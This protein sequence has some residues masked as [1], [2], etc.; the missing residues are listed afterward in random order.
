MLKQKLILS[1]GSK[2]GSQLLQFLGIVLIAR[3]LGPYSLGEISFAFAFVFTLSFLA[4]LGFGTAHVKLISEGENVDDCIA[5]FSMIKFILVVLFSILVLLIYN[6]IQLFNFDILSG[7]NND[8]LIYIFL[9]FAVVQQLTQVLNQT[10]LANIEQAKQDIPLL[11]QKIFLFVGRV[12]VLIYAP[13]VINLA[14]CQVVAVILSLPFSIYYFR[15]YKIGH[16]SWTLTKRYLA[17][18]KPSVITMI[19]LIL[20]VQIDKVLIQIFANSTEVGLYSAGYKVGAIFFTFSQAVN[21]LLFPVFTKNLFSGNKHN[22]ERILSKYENIS[23]SFLIQLIVGL[24]LF[25]QP[26]IVLLFG[27]EFTNAGDSLSFIFIATCIFLITI[28]YIN[29]FAAKGLFS[30]IAKNNIISFL[31]F[32]LGSLFLLKINLFRPSTTIAI[33]LSFF[34]L[35]SLILFFRKANAIVGRNT[36]I[37]LLISNLIPAFVLLAL[38][39]SIQLEPGT[40]ISLYLIFLLITNFIIFKRNLIDTNVVLYILD[41]FNLKKVLKYIKSELRTNDK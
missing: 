6:S 1:Y 35:T 15:D 24:V 40:I 34:Y 2:I 30:R 26:I 10:F 28:P 9:I 38:Y 17:I 8:N 21:Y 20:I 3:V 18:A 25:S 36:K 23:F 39:F 7:Y 16:F 31:F 4:D 5:T 14:I 11:I 32:L 41:M 13:T 19:V 22:I 27:I 37:S 33:S 12:G 29:V